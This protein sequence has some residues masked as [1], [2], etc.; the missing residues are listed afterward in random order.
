VETG[1]QPGE[2]VVTTGAYQVYLASLNT[3]Q[4]GSHGHP[5]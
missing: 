5:H 3:A 4:V 2:H 1:V